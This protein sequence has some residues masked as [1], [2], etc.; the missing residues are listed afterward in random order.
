MHISFYKCQYQLCFIFV[1]LNLETDLE[2]EFP[3]DLNDNNQSG[4]VPI[5]PFIPKEE[6]M[7]EEELE[8]MLGERYKPGS[9]FVTYAEDDEHK[10]SVDSV[11]MPSHKDST[12]WKV[13][14]TVN[15]VLFECCVNYILGNDFS[16]TSVSCSYCLPRLDARGTQLYVLC[17]NLR[18]CTIWELRCR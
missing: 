3:F 7:S 10:N 12:I 18:T 4:K 11:Y 13:K 2:D 6:E 14:C 5:P 8:R 1:F 15:V 16:H 17:K 9:G